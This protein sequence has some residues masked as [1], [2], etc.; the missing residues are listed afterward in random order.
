MRKPDYNKHVLTMFWRFILFPAVVVRAACRMVFG[1]CS[2]ADSRRTRDSVRQSRV[3][4]GLRGLTPDHDPADKR[5]WGKRHS[6]AP[7]AK[8]DVTH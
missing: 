6:P 1:W 2:T 3:R 5:S 4:R 8:V 7:A